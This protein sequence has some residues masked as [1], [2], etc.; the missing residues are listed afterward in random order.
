MENTALVS[1][2][3]RLVVIGLDGELKVLNDGQQPLPGEVVIAKND[4]DS[5]H[6]Q[7]QLVNEDGIQ[8]IS[9]DVAQIISALEQGQDPTQVGDEFAPAAGQTNGSSLQA[10]GTIDRIGAELLADTGFETNGLQALGL[11]Q[12]QSLTLLEQYTNFSPEFVGANN[13]PSGENML[14]TTDEDTPISGTLLA[15]DENSQDS[16]TFSQT[17]DPQNGTV[18]VNSDGTWT[19]TPN[20]DYDGPDRFVVTVSDGNGGTDT[21]EVNV[22]VTPIP[23]I[24]VSGGGDVSEGSDATYTI[25]YDKPSTQTTTL[26]LTNELG[27]AENNDVGELVIKTSSGEVLT[28]NPDGTVDVP[29]GTTSIIVTIPT[30]QDD[31]YERDESFTLNVESVSGLVGSGSSESVIKDDGTGPEVDPGP[32]N[33]KPELTVTGGG[34]VNEGS[35]AVFTVSLSNETEAPVVVNLAPTTDGYTAEAGDIGDMVVTYVDSNEQTQTLTVDSSGN[36]TI[37]AGVTD[38]TVTIPITQDKVYEGDESFGLVVTESNGV[39]SNGTVTGEATIKDDGMGPGPDTPDNDKPE[40]TITGGGAVNEGSD[41]VFTVSLS[42]ETEAPV[43][44]NLAPTTDGYTAEAG[45][46]GDMVVTY[47][48]SNEQTQT[49]TVDSSGNVT[50]PAGVTDITVTIPTTQD[51]VYE[52]DES[53][54]LVVTESNGVTSNGTVTGEA[55]IKDD[56]T[57]P[58]VDPGPDNDKPELTVTG[59][60]AVN[61]GSEAVFTVSLSNET[62]APVVVNL[63]PT[64]DGYTAE[65]GDIGDM[66]VTYVDS[67]EQTQ[68][69]TVDSSGNVT[70]PAGVTDITVTIPITQDKVYE[71]DESFGLVVTESN[72]VTSNGTVTGEATIKD[73]GMGPGPDTPDNDKPELT[74]TGG[75]AVNEGSDVVFTVSL[76]NETEAPVV[77]NLAPTTDGYTAE[78]GDIGDMVV[79]YVDSNE[80]T[81]T[82]TVDSSG[83]V[84]IPAGVTDITVTIPTTQDKVYEGDESFGLVV[85]ESNGVTSNGTVTGEAIIKD[86]GTGPEVDP[87]PDN[88]KP[89]LTVTGGGAVNEGSEAVFTVS[90]SNETE[91]PVVVNL[92]PTTDGYTAEAGDI[93]DMVVTYVDSNEQTQTLT[94]DSNGNVTIPAGVTDITV[95][96]PIT[97]DKVYEGDES[98]GLVVTESNGVTS[99]GTV[100]GEATIKDDGTG[101]DTPDNDK[102]ELTVTGGGAVNEGSD[103]VFTVSLSNETEAPVVVNLAPTTDGYTA[104][105]GDIGDMVVTY[106]DSN[107]QTQTLTV[108]SNGNV[109]IPAGVTDIT[110]TIPTTQDK[111][112]EGDESFGLVVT[113]SNGVTSNG[114]VT[115]E[116]TIKDDGTVDPD[117]PGGSDD[118]RPVVETVSSPIVAEGDTAV[119]EVELT[120]VSEL[121][122]EI[123]MNLTDGTATQDTDY[124]ATQVTVTYQENGVEKSETVEVVNGKF[125]FD[126]PA[127]NDGFTVSVVTTDDN[128]NPI[129]EGDETFTLGVSTEAQNGVTAGTATIKDDGTV[130]P[131]GPGGSDDDRPVVETV[132]SPIVAEGDTAVFEVEL[133]NVSELPTE[134]TMNLAD[135]TATQDTDYTATQVTV[136]YQENGVEKSETVEV[137]NGAFTFDLPANNDGFTVSVVTTDDNDNPIFEGDETFTL[138]VS[139]EAQN[140]VTTGTATIKD[141][142][143]VDPDGPG[144]SDDDRPVVE[145]VSSPIVAEGDTAVFEVE[146]TNVSELPTE[147]TMN[148]TDGT[149]TQDTDYTATQVTVTYQENGVEKSETVEVVNGKFTFDLPANN[150]GFTVSVVTTDD[151]DNPIFEGD[152]TFTLGVSTEAQNGVTTGTAT[153]KDDGTVDPDGPGGSDDDRPVVETVSS[154][155]V[156]EGDTAVF[157]VELTNVSELPTE[158]TMNLT[159]GTATQDTDYTA[160]QVTVTYQENG[161]EKSETVEVVNGKFT[162]DL[163]ANN[164]GFTVSVVTT[165]D[166][167]NPIFE[168]DETFTLGVS[169]EAQNGVTTGTATI[170]DDGTVDPDG[171]GGSDDDRPVVETVSSPIVAEGDTAVFEVELT[172]VSE[173]PTEI[174][175]NLTDGT[176]TQD[177]D[178]T[179]TQVTVTYQENGVEKSETVEVV[180]GKFTFDLPANNDGFT[181]SV[182]TTDDNDNPIFEGDETFTLGVSTE[183]QNGVTTGTATIKDDG[184][185]DPDG[186]GGS[187]DDRPVVETVSSPIV[188][189]G[190]TA[191]FEVELTNVSELPTEITMNLTD[192]TATQDTDYTATQV[193]VTYQENGVEK[194]ETV[195]VVN[196]KFTFDLPAN[197][198]GFTVSVVTTDDNDNPIFEGDET[199]TLGV[200]TEAQNGVTAG[201]ATIKDDGTVDPDGPGGSDDD[202]P[203]VET[204]SSPIVA[205]GDTAVFEV[206]LT[207][208]SELPTEITMNLTDGT[209]TQDTDY[210]ATQVTV[211]YQENGVEKSETVEVVNGAFTFDLPANNDGFT[212]SV[213]TTDDNDNPI[214]EGDET[215]TLGV[216]TEAQNGVTTGTATIKDDGT[217]DPDGP[218]GSDDD[219]PVVE[220][221]SSPIV[222]EGDTAV[223]EVELTNVSELPTEITMNLTDGTAT[224][225]TDYTATQVTVTYQENGV[226]KSETVE[227]VNGKF[228][229]DLPANNDG[230]TVSVVTTDDNDNPI[231]EGD[232]TFTLSVSTEAQNDAKSGQATIQ[233]YEDNP[234]KSEDFSVDVANGERT[235]VIFDHEE[236]TK[237][238]ISDAEDDASDEQLQIVITELPDHGTLYHNGVEITEDDLYQ[239]EGDAT[240]S[241][242]DPDLIEYQPDADSEGFALGINSD[243]DSQP[244]GQADKDSSSTDFYN[245]GEH[246]DANTR[247]LKLSDDDTV[248]IRSEGG[249]LTQY[250]GDENANHVGHGIGIGGKQGINEGEKLIVEFDSRPADSVTLGLDG[251]GGYFEKGLGT[252]KESSVVITVNY[253]GGSETFEF[254]KDA[255]GNDDLYHSLVIPSAGF[256]LPEGAEITSI[257]LSTDGPGNW[258][259][260]S[261][262][263]SLSDSF[264]YQAVDS[265]GNFSD[266]STVTLEE[267]NQGPDAVNDPVRFE[268]KLGS[269]NEGS[270][271]SEDAQISAS[272]AG[273][274]RDITEDGDKRGVSGHENGGDAEQIQF[275]RETGESEQFIIDLDKPATEFSFTVSNLYKDEGDSAGNHEQGKWVA[276]LNGVVVASDTFVANDGNHRGEYK[277]ELTNE[278]GTPIAFD[279][280][281][282]EAT[283]FVDVP[284]KGSDSSDYFVTGFQASSE[285]AYA[286]NQGGV[287]EIPVSEL[288]ANDSDIDGDSIRIT[289]VYGETEGEAYIKDGVVYFHLDEDFVGSTNFQYQITD[290]K[291]GYDSATVNVIVNP[292]PTP[293]V[294]DSV[295]LLSNEVMEGEDL[296]FKVTLDASALK[297]TH[298][299]IDFGLSGDLADENDVDLSELVFTNGVTYD[300]ATDK[301]IIPVGV[302]DFTVLVPTMK[303]GVHELDESYSIAVGGVEGT[304]TIKNTDVAELSVSSKGDV[305]E[306][307]EATFSVSLSNPSSQ[308]TVLSLVTTVSGDENTAEIDDLSGSITAFY[309][310]ADDKEIALTVIDGKV[311]VPPFVTEIFVEVGT[312]DDS[313]YEGSEQFELIVTDVNGVTSNKSD[314]ASTNIVDDGSVDPDGPMGPDNDK[315]TL[316][317]TDVGN[318]N[319]GSDAVFTVSLSNETEAP[320]VVN[321]A[322][323]TDGYTAEVGDI[324]DMVVTYLDGDKQTQTL[325][326]DSNGNVTI[327]AGVT[328][329]TVTIPTTQDS[330][331]EGDETFGLVVT[332]SNGVTMNG[333]DQAEAT[334]QDYDDD[335]PNSEDFSINIGESG[336]SKVIFDD[337]KGSIEGDGSDHI[338]DEFDDSQ[339]DTQVGV[340]ITELPDNGTLTYDGVEITVDDLAVF[341]EQGNVLQEGTVFENPNL[342]EYTRDEHAEGFLLGVRDEQNVD[343]DSPSKTDFYNWGEATDDPSVRKLTLADGDI[344]TITADKE[345]QGNDELIQY[346]SNANHV[347]YGVGVGKGNGIEERESITI[348]FESRPADSITLGLDGLGGYFEKG[349]D[350]RLNNGSSNESKVTIDVTWLDANGNLKTTPF[351]YQKETK[352]N[353]DLF[354]E[355]VIPSAQFELPNGAM[356]ESVEL[357][358][359]GNGNWELRYIDTRS[360]DS[361]DYRAVDSHG[362]YSDESTVTINNAPDAVDDPQAYT[363]QLGSFADNQNWQV[364]GVEIKAFIGHL[365]DRSEDIE[366]DIETTDGHKLGVDGDISTG[367][368]E[369]LQYDRETGQSEKLEITLPKPATSFSFAVASLYANEGGTENHEQGMWTAYLDGKPVQSGVFSLESGKDGQF[370]VDLESVAFDSIVFEA[371]EFTSHP[372]KFEGS[373]N[374][375]S[376]YFLTGFEATGTGAYAV[377]QSEGEIRIPISEILANDVDIDGDAL[378]ITAFNEFGEHNV[379]IEGYE[380]VF[381]FVDSFHGETSFTYTITDGNGASDTATI[382]VIVN[383]DVDLVSVS[384]VNT[385]GT[386]VEEG[387]SLTFV[388]N[389]S[390][391][392]QLGQQLEVDF[393]TNAGELDAASSADVKSGELQFTN[394]VTYNA[395]TGLLFVPPGVESFEIIIPTV[396][397]ILDES[398]ENYTISVGGKESTGSILDNDQPTVDKV[399]VGQPSSDDDQVVEGNDLNFNVSLSQ[400]PNSDAI[401]TINLPMSDD[402]DLS[403]VMVSDGVTLNDDGTITVEAGVKDFTI[404]VPTVDDKEVELTEDYT[405]SVGGITST[406]SILDNDKAINNTPPEAKSVNLDTIGGSKEVIFTELVSDK[407][408]DQDPTQDINLVIESEPLF[409]DIYYINDDGIRMDLSVGDVI[410]EDTH[411]QYTVNPDL[412]SQNSSLIA[413][414]LDP[415]VLGNSLFTVDGLFTVSGGTVTKH[416]NEYQFNQ[417]GKLLYDQAAGE[418]GLSV[419]T[420]G[421]GNSNDNGDE[422]SSDEY[423]A[424]KF[425]SVDVNTATVSL[426]SINGLFNSGNDQNKPTLTALYFKDG[427]LVGSDDLVITETESGHNK[428]GIATLD[429]DNAFDEVRFVLDAKNGSAG[430]VLQGVQVDEIS[431]VTDIVDSFDYKAVD[432]QG[433]ESDSATV[434]LSS[435][436]ITISSNPEAIDHVRVNHYGHASEQVL[437]SASGIHPGISNKPLEGHK[438]G[439]FVDVGEGG[440]TVYLG[441]GDDTIYLGRS[442]TSLDEHQNQ[443]EN[444]TAVQRELIDSFSSGADGMHLEATDDHF[445]D[446]DLT[447]DTMTEFEENSDLVFHKADGTAGSISTA[448]LDIAH[449]GGGND[450]IFGE[451]GSDAIFG[452]SGND[453]IYGGKGLDVLRGGTGDDHIDGGDGSDFLIGGSGNDILVGGDGDDIFKFVDQGDGIRDGEMDIVK[454]F[455]S[456]EDTLDLSELL[457]SYD[458]RSMDDV[459]SVTLEGSDDLKVTIS[460]GDESQSIVLENAA[461][462]FSEHISDGNVSDS[463]LNDLL[464]VQDT[465]NS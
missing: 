23:E 50:I 296:A 144:G 104:E 356:I 388:V 72:G 100:T 378:T 334:I 346:S 291:G 123:T 391:E 138:G 293:A 166:N 371:T 299:D 246:V 423:I 57:G 274:K 277:V 351:E 93:G 319:E 307:S 201:T 59:G 51:K 197:N 341:D 461:S 416:G 35:D 294:V 228:T 372:D 116:A 133:T 453:T 336:T 232:E 74:I 152:E 376:D 409:G 185:V 29:A 219:R 169:T 222:A 143:T 422:I 292:D 240:Y 460:D 225:D 387:E 382:N 11:S 158:I 343:N 233:D 264:D 113:E 64:T 157:E 420:S 361:F 227:V 282:F 47:V 261:L 322:P 396:D 176:A 62:E 12:T 331:Y 442:H 183:A 49:L 16:L 400:A 330:V 317:V 98:F 148:L 177:T 78:A 200:S 303:D 320:V 217:V 136:T 97:Q 448:N 345:G 8:D 257:E 355:I 323:T 249:K 27:T 191:V 220:T 276:Y 406:G 401:Y 195:E 111:V 427:K 405:I 112:Y 324:G 142:G 451:E 279:K 199:F 244:L 156:A 126:L 164:D 404:T 194:S 224:Q 429:S 187:D 2:S 6:V 434:T 436:N 68:T 458:D 310:D 328:D 134:I 139:T 175:M 304:G 262:E 297:E 189:E 73:D 193:T 75:G 167:D 110:V 457:D 278:D 160:T 162:F 178:Y 165:D 79:T 190:D 99:N 63:A 432:S 395:N 270:W 5:E 255:S 77:V 90:L 256:E 174:T 337:G 45:D 357:S 214:F 132:S 289:Y 392:S 107:E 335:K 52:G 48:D 198:D 28:V 125:T 380:V 414:N 83:N 145:T 412:I 140:G 375:S 173:L 76:S 311:T 267:V 465:F 67:N 115:G 19:Y 14:V 358:T 124:T 153:I 55:I 109:T 131:D 300:E 129:F 421:N 7:V 288:L 155:I 179:A 137:V 18:V 229:F 306:G 333:S 394:G 221:V 101:P 238:H 128:D 127:N 449:A 38:I 407:E 456:G 170:K 419:K 359:E 379:R 130:D 85:T 308:E 208:V 80:Q 119:F 135:G 446:D 285:G 84:T 381:D 239:G 413:E 149:A 360:D 108:D 92:A 223:F 58:E 254:Q 314:S 444:L 15:T 363:V 431:N 71:G 440:D 226:E 441:S 318:V 184:T 235:Q 102:P 342:I 20:E 259:L 203:V 450:I 283:D 301:I 315:P 211:T 234:P 463:I 281:V 253:K 236:S 250:S 352:G 309:I 141:D 265:D 415:S 389:L 34:E 263:T 81:Q 452:G 433:L 94:V 154:P 218:G 106:V 121:P 272:Y 365:G 369:Q 417:T 245:W 161:V 181:V 455:T 428:E 403:K 122:T 241:K 159:D 313:I 275:N 462:Q 4:A 354:H 385:L 60:G 329:I 287:L 89:E 32:D 237:D 435:D 206:E 118:D 22:N 230:F 426:G 43:V 231:F 367:P 17:S 31:I 204:V 464:K 425:E 370:S 212:V 459:L 353:S 424:V 332:E 9:D 41:V 70:I 163:P 216:S 150:D 242:F 340:V 168:G 339:P 321:L 344:I 37:P 347:G 44:V 251:L 192:G 454:D 120:N 105:A 349:L 10:S 61:E 86:D 103:A 402:V 398:S 202:R 205:E 348:D 186:P 260:R 280:I 42:N 215:F 298:L 305:S 147:I 364:D 410:T 53:F 373:D 418:K 377:N 366:R 207:N 25:S 146:L 326:V 196:G 290:D 1:L 188:A 95:T 374:D 171:P 269:F 408:D 30:S 180:N 247:E 243:A 350:N 312:A 445:R 213:V 273:E 248:T 252:S 386:E 33:D 271:S 54:G 430:Y 266:V 443:E 210:T 438:E 56:G 362:N 447:N 39:T 439:L 3:G 87:G 40:L 26:K 390:A 295:E 117:G 91:A 96:I 46:I 383:P 182:V 21:L 82:L 209:A 302:K 368:G 13:A 437:W 69:L 399:E 65:A 172:N 327:P 397:D 151:N 393:G 316:S 384:S 284:A 325:T 66:V 114:T 24:S 36:V 258:E 411:I 88:D 338:S 268:V 286:V